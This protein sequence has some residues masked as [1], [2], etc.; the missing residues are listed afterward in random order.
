ME[1]RKKVV[2]VT[3]ASGSMGSEVLKQ[4]LETKKFKGL[5]LLRQKPANE[6]LAKKL[7]KKYGTDIK[8]VFGDLSNADDCVKCVAE[9]DY[10]IHCAAIIP[11][12]S[13]HNPKQAEKANF[14]GTKN[15][16]D[17]INNSERKNDIKLVAI[18]TVAEYG[19]RDY[20]HPW[21]RVGD[22]LMVSAYDFYAVTKL[23]A[24]RY[25][26][27]SGLPNWVSLRQSGILYDNLLKNNMSDGLMFHTCWNVPIEWVTS[28]D[29]G[30]MLKNLVERDSEGTLKPGFWN[31]A[32]NIGGGPGCRVTGFDTV[33]AGFKLMGGSA[34]DFFQPNWSAARNFHCLWYEDS[35]VLND[36]LDFQTESFDAFWANM[37][38]LYWYF[39]FGAL[40]PK[41]LI[42]KL[43]IEKLLTNSNA[44]MYWI[45]KNISGRINAFFGSRENW[46]K[47]P[48]T[49]DNY[50]LLRDGQVYDNNGNIAQIDYEEL[51]NENTL[52]S[53]NLLLSHGYDESKADSE[54]DLADMQSAAK[55]RGGKVLSTTMKKGDLHTKLKWQCHNGH[56]FESTPY[57]IVKA[58]HWCPECCAPTPWNFDE[59]SKHIPF[60][61][62][63]WYDTHDKSEANF[64]SEDCYKDILDSNNK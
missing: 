7:E 41:K 56:T 61:A 18:A 32:Y 2:F 16:V 8:V 50:P 12:V 6:K 1:N 13:D 63:V 15:L 10:I 47:I 57:T 52:H 48:A 42:R 5:V 27:D 17:A 55:F 14:F 21:G 59:L 62:Q 35:H 37:A 58:G 40:A 24:E 43:T 20:R 4:I 11:P 36:Y 19:N 29:S 33:D 60:F 49:W 39:K 54:L 28:R 31:R 44:P 53:K 22:P 38:K 45:N 30:L 3:G 9:S 64:Y 23:R 51:K 26:L 46:E 34:K 25:V